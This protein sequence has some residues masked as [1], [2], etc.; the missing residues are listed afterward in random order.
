MVEKV[1]IS[2]TGESGLFVF[3]QDEQER[4]HSGGMI[5]TNL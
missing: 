1:N 3:G 5:E 4:Y 2:K